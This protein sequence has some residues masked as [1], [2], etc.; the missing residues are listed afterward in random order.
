MGEGG[1]HSGHRLRGSCVCPAFIARLNQ[2]TSRYDLRLK[3]NTAS[4]NASIPQAKM[5]TTH[6]Y[7][8]PPL[9]PTSRKMAIEKSQSAPEIPPRIIMNW[10]IPVH[11][12]D[13]SVGLLA[14]AAPEV[15]EPLAVQVRRPLRRL[16]RWI[17]RGKGRR[18][19]LSRSRSRCARSASTA[20]DE[21]AWSGCGLMTSCACWRFF[22]GGDVLY[23]RRCPPW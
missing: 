20:S 7:R 12:G 10:F 19:R 13:T 16:A 1:D 6:E 14:V 15:T 8:Q 5:N 23:R 9:S 2:A 3:A 18:Q 4:I 11:L 21:G 22:F 17:A